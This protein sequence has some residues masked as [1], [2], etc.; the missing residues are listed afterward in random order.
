MKLSEALALASEKL[1]TA[2]VPSPQADATWLLCHILDTDRSDLLTR[3]T[4]DQDLSSEQLEAFLVA[5]TRREKREPLQH[6]TGKAA[7]RSLELSVGPGV[8]IPRPETEQVVQ[9]AIDYLRQLPMPGVAIDLGTGSGAIAIAMAVEVPQTK[10]YA[11]ELSQSAFDYATKNIEANLAAVEL[12]LGAMQEVVSDLVGGV[13][14]VI[15]NPPY[16]PDSAIPI[17]PEV[18]NF[19]PELAL[20]GG[21]DGLDVIRDISG[22]AAALLRAGGLL[23]LEHAETQSDAIRELLLNDGWLSVSAFQDAAMRYRT[24]TAIR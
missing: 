11:V 9:Y 3:I 19:D 14:V 24:I 21:E 6:I 16:I 17:D 20:Y 1:S 13:D 8:F 10:V 15:S 7:F 18:R 5:L 22:I 4:F 12:R 2:G 23:V